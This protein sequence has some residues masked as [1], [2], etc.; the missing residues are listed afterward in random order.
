[1]VMGLLL[2]SMDWEDTSNVLNVQCVCVLS[3][4]KVFFLKTVSKQTS[5][6]VARWATENK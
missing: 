5:V 3:L 1:M 4:N 2:K 6:Y